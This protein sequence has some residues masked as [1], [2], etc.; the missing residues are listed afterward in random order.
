MSIALA[1]SRERRDV[2]H[3]MVAR[4]GQLDR[5]AAD[6]ARLIPL[7]GSHLLELSI[8]FVGPALVGMFFVL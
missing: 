4:L 7:L 6:R 3:D 1:F 2:L 8:L 5:H